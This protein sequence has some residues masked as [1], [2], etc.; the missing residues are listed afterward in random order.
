MRGALAEAGTP[1][2]GRER[3]RSRRRWIAT[4]G[5]AV[6]VAAGLLAYALTP[7]SA[8]SVT[9]SPGGGHRVVLEGGHGPGAGLPKLASGVEAPGFSLARLGGGAPVS[10][11]SFRGHPVVLNFF[12]SWCPD[13][14]A[15]LHAFATVS[16][17]S[18]GDVRFVAVDT[19]DPN[20]AKALALLRRAGDRYPTGIDPHATVANSRYYIEALPVTVFIRADGRIGGEA[21]G[22]QTVT[23]L[24]SWVRALEKGGAQA[25]KGTT[26]R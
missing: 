12:A 8:T 3:R 2:L 9:M 4:G 5:L 11:S 20:T 13:C 1:H 23:S 7:Q 18:H 10:L 17:G 16:N 26:T 19:N 15:E 25:G 21:F 14:R 24:R 22:A 6:A